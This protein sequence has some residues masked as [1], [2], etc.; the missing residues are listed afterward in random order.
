MCNTAV[1]LGPADEAP[2]RVVSAHF[3]RLHAALARALR[4]AKRRGEL[5]PG[6]EPGRGADF[7]LGVLQG[8]F[9]LVR[10]GQHPETVSGILRSGLRAVGDVHPWLASRGRIPPGRGL[11]MRR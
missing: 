4:N 7:L 1:E 9:V 10:G 5:S 3:R 8:A 6:L 2:V 11:P